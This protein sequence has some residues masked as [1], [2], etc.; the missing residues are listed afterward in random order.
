MPEEKYNPDIPYSPRE[1]REKWHDQANVSQQILAQAQRTNGSIAD[2]NR[3][4]E[5]VNGAFLASSVFMAC[6]ILPI[7]GWALYVLININQTVHSAVDESL[8]AYDI[9]NDPKNN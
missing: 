2:I 9:S 4:R 1:I 8:S 6:V 5:R 3:W 7:L